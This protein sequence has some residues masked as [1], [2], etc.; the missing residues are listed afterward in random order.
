MIELVSGET[1]S[2]NCNTMST[3]IEQWV[4][5]KGYSR[6]LVSTLGRVCSANGILEPHIGP[7][8][9]A[10]VSLTDDT[11]AVKNP[12]VHRL[13]AGAFIPNPENKPLVDHINHKRSDNRCVNL[14]WA[15]YSE[16]AQGNAKAS[17]TNGRI[18][19]R[20]DQN[21]TLIGTWPSV[22]ALTRQY[23]VLKW[24]IYKACMDGTMAYDSHWRYADT[25]SI[26][27]EEWR[28]ILV[29]EHKIKAS[30]MGRVELLS[31]RFTYG[32]KNNSGYLAVHI[33]ELTILVHRI[34]CQAFFPISDPQNFHVNHK[35][36]N[37]RNNT[38]INLEW[39]TASENA[40]HT[41]TMKGDAKSLRSVAQYTQFGLLAVVWPSLRNAAKA[42]GCRKVSDIIKSCEDRIDLCKG[43]IWRYV[44]DGQIPPMF[45]NNSL[46]KPLAKPYR[47]V[48]QFTLKDVFVQRFDSCREASQSVSTSLYNIADAC[49]GKYEVMC[50]FIWR[51][52]T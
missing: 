51:W 46:I 11:G 24:V 4:I 6:Y 40:R 34:I 19:N 14:R 22:N 50:G 26:P 44:E 1:N 18:V 43:F 30:S 16:N 23:N 17:K 15:T 41:V 3:E 28:Q 25:V 35:D 5:I 38:S 20:Y 32:H 10:D 29:G 7:A 12:R 48:S 49:D 2:A 42:I 36:G 45:L 31:G 39:V 21:G 33:G 8:G 13:M 47:P 37:K 9:Y 27:G 52:C